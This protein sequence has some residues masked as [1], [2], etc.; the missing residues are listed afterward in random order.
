RFFASCAII[1]MRNPSELV[2][3]VVVNLLYHIS[4]GFSLFLLVHIILAH[5]FFEEKF[6]EIGENDILVLEI[7][8]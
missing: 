5:T 4:V 6:W 3:F 2:F 8:F 7:E 1:F